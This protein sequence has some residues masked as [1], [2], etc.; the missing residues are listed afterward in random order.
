MKNKYIEKENF[1]LA[2]NTKIGITIGMI[3][4]LF[5]II[6]ILILYIEGFFT[7]IYY[8][9]FQFGKRIK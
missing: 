9:G 5:I 7:H 2:N 8:Y 1:Y 6:L 3:I 4:L